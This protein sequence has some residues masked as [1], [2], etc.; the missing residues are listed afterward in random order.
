M[1][2]IRPRQPPT[3]EATQYGA[4]AARGGAATEADNARVW[5]GAKAG[6]YEVWYLTCNHRASRTG[7]WIRYTL[8][9]PLP[10]HGEPYGQLWFGFFDRNDPARTFGIN[11]RVSIGAHRATAAPFAV[12]MGAARLTHGGMHGALAGG[13]HTVRWDLRWLPDERTYHQLPAVFYKAP[14]GDTTVLTPNLDVPI[15][16]E[17]EVDGTVYDFDGEPGGQTHLWGRKHAHAWAWAHC[18]AFEG[19]RGVAFESLTAVLRRR[20]VVLPPLT[21]LGLR[22]DGETLAF[23]QL[24][25]MPLN[26]GRFATARYAFAAVSPTA[27]L[28][29]ELTCR[30]DDMILTEYA[31][32]D[33]EAS[34]C[35]NTE[36]ADLYL[37]VWR[38]GLLGRFV[39]DRTLRAPGTGHFEIARREPDPAILKRHVR[40]D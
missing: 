17:I 24:R 18:N 6:H 9:A 26:R 34:F 31:D 1:P 12:E 16:G 23:N 20:G 28:E 36:V 32:P 30:P 15:R 4:Q 11:K 10:G 19:A 33:G 7:Y 40:I 21:V 14:L 37:R 3:P 5:D 38:R 35:A 25:H 27:R 22:L 13:G 2:T 8:E 39:E 29:G